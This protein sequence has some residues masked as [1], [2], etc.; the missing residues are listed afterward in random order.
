M[1]KG[2]ARRKR[3]D[4]GLV[5]G[6]F[7]PLHRG[8]MH[9]IDEARRQ[10]NHVTVLVGTL[11]AEPIP[12]VLRY[13]WMQELYPDL[14]VQH[15]T[16]ENPQYPHEHP[17]FWA[18]WTRSIR[19]F[20]PTGPDAVFSSEAY[21]DTLAACLGAEHVLVDLDRTTVPVSGTAIRADPYRYWD[22]LPACVRSYFV[23]KVALIGPEAT[24]K[25]TL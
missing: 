2:D 5:L 10:A 4:T 19:R 17:D 1:E 9:L 11:A 25:K 15:L 14:N 7:L 24:K 13:R 12:G 22:F 8:H 16:D 6:K 18:I 3:Y 21:G 23:K 20:I